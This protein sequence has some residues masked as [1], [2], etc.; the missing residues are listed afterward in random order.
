MNWDAIGAVGEVLGAIGVLVTLIYLAFQIR[1][2]S[3]L[4]K[5]S[6]DQNNA[7]NSRNQFSLFQD[8][9]TRK[10]VLKAFHTDEELTLEEATAAEAFFMGSMTSF[11]SQ[12]FNFS[13]GAMSEQEWDVTK[14]L[15]AQYFTTSWPRAWWEFAVLGFDPKF[16]VIVNQIVE[17]QE[18]SGSHLTQIQT[19][20]SEIRQK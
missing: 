14:A 20:A 3:K 7:E 18:L 12:Y 16:V 17:A 10:A 8:S 2:N 6:V 5:S 13:S 19:R 4:L 9:Y 11:Q 1:L 15:I